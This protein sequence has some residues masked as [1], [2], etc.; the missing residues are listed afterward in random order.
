MVDIV[1]VFGAQIFV[2]LIWGRGAGEGWGLALK[3]GKEIA[4]IEPKEKFQPGLPLRPS[5]LWFLCLNANSS[6]WT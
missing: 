1:A 4:H 2:A 5:Y 6:F 3:G